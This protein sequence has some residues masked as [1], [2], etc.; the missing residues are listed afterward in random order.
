MP[1]S[2]GRK[3]DRH[4]LQSTEE[5]LSEPARLDLLLEVT[6]DRSNDTDIDANIIQTTDQA[7]FQRAARPRRD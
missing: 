3:R 1:L 4:H 2:Q 6:I 5:I 7:P